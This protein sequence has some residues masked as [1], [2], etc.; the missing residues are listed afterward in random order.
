MLG[1]DLPSIFF[2]KAMNDIAIQSDVLQRFIF[3][4]AP[5][6]GE[7]VHLSESWQHVLSRREY[8]PAIQQLLGEMMAA[9]ALLFCL[10]AQ[11]KLLLALE[12]W[13]C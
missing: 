3:D 9:A 13:P 5:V 2:G 10:A 7:W 12:R 4:D 8:P 6:R 11:E 1:S